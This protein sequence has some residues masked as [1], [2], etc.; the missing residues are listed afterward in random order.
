MLALERASSL[1][2][3]VQ[4]QIQHRKTID[5]AF[6]KDLLDFKVVPPLNGTKAEEDEGGFMES[7]DDMS[8]VTGSVCSHTLASLRSR[9]KY[10]A[11]SVSGRS[12]MSR[13][14][15]AREEAT[16]RHA[17]R[18]MAAD[19][20]GGSSMASN[21]QYQR[22]KKHSSSN[23][24]ASI[25]K[26]IRSSSDY[27]LLYDPYKSKNDT[28]RQPQKVYEDDYCNNNPFYN[29]S[30]IPPTSHSPRR[31]MYSMANGSAIRRASSSSST[32][33]SRIKFNPS[34]AVN[35]RNRKSAKKLMPRDPAAKQ[36]I[37]ERMLR[38]VN[39]VDS[40]PEDT[41]ICSSVMTD[42]S[43]ASRAL[44]KR[45]NIARLRK[46][47]SHTADEDDDIYR[48]NTSSNQFYYPDVSC[49]TSMSHDPYESN[50][51]NASR[52]LRTISSESSGMVSNISKK[53]WQ[54]CD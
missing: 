20:M 23:S 53:G 9:T 21:D 7:D 39:S 1:I 50:T 2:K 31:S 16:S 11:P 5:G 19:H 10:P 36:M 30:A 3:K 42:R 47:R 18:M 26:S 38:V 25:S 12:Q 52:I 34:L 29:D 22:R 28:E 27:D 33:S 8:S 40:I 54:I 37:C 49:S 45:Q 15:S 44:N 17:Y 6:G 41:T 51:R 35:S 46:A 4:I 32:G 13:Y 48:S 14:S 24:Q 43:S